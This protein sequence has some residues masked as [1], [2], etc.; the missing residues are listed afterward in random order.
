MKK[1]PSEDYGTVASLAV[2]KQF[3]NL[4]HKIK[5][6]TISAPEMKVFT[7]LERRI[8]SEDG[9][10]D[11]VTYERADVAKRFKR[12]DRTIL[13]WIKDG[14]PMRPDGGFCIADIQQWMDEKKQ[15]KK[16]PTEDSAEYWQTQ[17]KKHRAKLSELELQIKKGELLAKADVMVAFRE[18]QSYVKKHLALLPRTA[19]G[20]LSGQDP[21]G[22]QITLSEL[23]TAIL[24]NMSKGQNAST[25]E[26]KLK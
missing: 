5:D 13:N 15:A 17:Y 7:E 16:N 14:M 23:T 8:K 22:M 18:M 4:L 19:P 9:K 24:S 12:S 3:E 26:A 21:Q 6:G 1:P 10:E 2:K 11:G 20:K 25:L